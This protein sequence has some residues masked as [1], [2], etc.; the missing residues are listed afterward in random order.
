MT[1]ASVKPALDRIEKKLDQLLEESD[2]T[3]AEQDTK[4]VE[5][6]VCDHTKEVMEDG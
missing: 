5:M 6:S 3:A 2:F 1:H 4:A